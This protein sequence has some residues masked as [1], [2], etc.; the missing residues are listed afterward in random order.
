MYKDSD[1]SALDRVVLILSPSLFKS[2]LN[3]GPYVKDTSVQVC[4][5][6]YI[7]DNTAECLPFIRITTFHPPPLRATSLV[8]V[9]PG[10]FLKLPPALPQLD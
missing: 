5:L 7:V 9:T 2:N 4:L 1:A 3:S 6:T 8:H 10:T